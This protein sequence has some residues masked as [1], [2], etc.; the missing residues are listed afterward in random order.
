MTLQRRTLVAGLAACAMAPAFGQAFPNRPV[1]VIVPSGAGG[2]ADIMMRTLGPK[3]AEKLG[4]P[5]VIENRAGAAGTLGLAATAKS[6]ADGYTLVFIS[7]THAGAE[8]MYPQRGYALLKDLVPVA[9][10][11]DT[12]MV[13]V[14]NP[15]VPARTLAEFVALAKSQPTRLCYAS[16]GNG[17]IY[18]LA[19]ELFMKNTG[20]QFTH[21]PYSNVGVGRTDVMS[22]QVQFMFDAIASIL[23]HIQ[24]GKVRPLAVT[25]AR[26][27]STLPDVPTVAETVPGYAFDVWTGLVAP[28]GTPAPAIARLHEAMESALRDPDVRSRFQALAAEPIFE[29]P[30]KFG[31]RIRAGIDKWADVIRTAGIKAD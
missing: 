31:E 3:M 11:A 10:I 20:T 28:A 14:V 6:P 1:R 18:H 5:V 23:P 4:Q 21:V 7:E 27:S 29:P 12:A 24:S 26:R 13:L 30:A 16:G 2:P 9:A 22:G 17:N 25:G 8:S 15:G 19:T